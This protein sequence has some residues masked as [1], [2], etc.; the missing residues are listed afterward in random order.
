LAEVAPIEAVR[1]ELREAILREYS[2]ATEAHQAVG[3]WIKSLEKLNATNKESI[4]RLLAAIKPGLSLD[5]VDE[6]ARKAKEKI[7]AKISAFSQ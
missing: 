2:H 7:E 1:K 4:E 3:G 6:A 5:S